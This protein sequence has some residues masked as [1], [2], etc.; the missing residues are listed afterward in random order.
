MFIVC[1][2][3]Y[4]VSFRVPDKSNRPAVLYAGECVSMAFVVSVAGDK[5]RESLIFESFVEVYVL[6]DNDSILVS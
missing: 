6:F 4:S 5:W 2:S 3:K 1:L